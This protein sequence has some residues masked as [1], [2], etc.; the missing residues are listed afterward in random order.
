MNINDKKVVKK[1]E[2]KSKDIRMQQLNDLRT[3]LSNNSGMRVVWRLLEACN[4]FGS[5]YNEN[6]TH[7]AY[8]SGKQDLGHFIM[9]EITEADENLLFKMM[10]MNM[11]KEGQ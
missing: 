2:Q 1:L 8:K 11:K 10:K 6:P 7:A 9:S 3:V 4:T 5:T